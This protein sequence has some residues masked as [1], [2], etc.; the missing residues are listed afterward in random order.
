MVG[1]LM[2]DCVYRRAVQQREGDKRVLR[3]SQY[4][5][6]ILRNVMRS[7]F[8]FVFEP[9]DEISFRRNENGGTLWEMCGVKKW[10]RDSGVRARGMFV[11]V[12]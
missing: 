4:D 12:H 10:G 6:R 8:L 7:S 2:S 11:C 1:A 9:C 5:L 3:T